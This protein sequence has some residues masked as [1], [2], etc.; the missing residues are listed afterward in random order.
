MDTLFTTQAIIDDSIVRAKDEYKTQWPDALL[1]KILNRAVQYTTHLLFNIHSELVV[2]VG[3]VTLIAGTQEYSLTDNLPDFMAMMEDG[4]YFENE[5]IL[6]PITYEDKRREKA[7]TTDIA[8]LFYYITQDSIGVVNIPTATS[9]SSF[10]TLT[11][12][13]FKRFP[14]LTLLSS[15]PYKNLFNEPLSAFMDNMAM[16]KA[17]EITAECTAIYNALEES[18]MSIAKKRGQLT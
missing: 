5:D 14:D 4:V 17:E 6:L 12:R 16:L 7:K 13:Y 18:T 15:M 1:L 11:C 9:V 8:P 10:P 2:N 3:T